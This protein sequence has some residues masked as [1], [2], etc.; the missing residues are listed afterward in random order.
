MNFV[1]LLRGINVS[2]KHKILM[3][4]FVNLMLQNSKITNIKSYIQSGNFVVNSN[5]NSTTGLSNLFSKIILKNYNY[6]ITT[7]CFTVDEFEDIVKNYPFNSENKR[8]Y[9]TF[10]KENNSH[11][12]TLD[13]ITELDTKDQL[14]IYKNVIYVKYATKYSDS[15]INNNFF[16]KKLKVT[17]TT[18][19]LNTVNKIL[20]IAKMI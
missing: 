17:A 14:S 16:E 3:K 7:L 13:F 18:R 11:Q 10:F 15:K 2:G 5:I 1:V 4:D 9:I 8:D 19:N 20:N 12:N 6:E